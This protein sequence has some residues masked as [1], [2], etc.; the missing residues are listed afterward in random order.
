M[1]WPTVAGNIALAADALSKGSKPDRA[2]L[3]AKSIGWWVW[4]TPRT[5]AR[6]SCRAVC[7]SGSRW[8]GLWRWSLRFC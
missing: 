2:A 4:P 3:V 7:A 5:V 8:R 1:P 6:P